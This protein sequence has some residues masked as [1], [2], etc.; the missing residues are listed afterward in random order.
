[1]IERYQKHVAERG[2]Q[3]TAPLPLDPDQ[4]TELCQLL[5]SPPAGQDQFL[6]DLF[7]NRVPPG[8]DP[9]AQVKAEFLSH[10]LD[11]KKTSPLLSRLRAVQILGTMLGG[12]NVAP[13]IAALADTEL[14]APFSGVMARKLV[15][16]FANVTAKQPVLVLTDAS[17]LEIK[18][19]ARSTRGW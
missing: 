13:L 7:E 17:T 18:S 15:Q 14:T 3:G 5:E 12:Y 9:A 11:G 4:T 16:D 2:A 8:V 19:F 1:M 6:L 10:I